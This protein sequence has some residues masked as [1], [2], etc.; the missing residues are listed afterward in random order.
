MFMGVL[1]S[2][3][4]IS[5]WDMLRTPSLSPTELHLESS[6][7]TSGRDTCVPYNSMPTLWR[8]INDMDMVARVLFAPC[9]LLNGGA[10]DDD[11]MLMTKGVIKVRISTFFALADPQASIHVG[12]LCCRHGN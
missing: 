8:V 3:I 4:L 5:P 1:G 6:V 11:H 12:L 2:V 9:T 10:G 7:L